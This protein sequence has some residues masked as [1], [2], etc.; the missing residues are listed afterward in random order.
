MLYNIETKNVKT[1]MDCMECPH[2]DKKTKECNGLGVACFEY[3]Q[4][5]QTCLDPVTKLPFNPN[6]QK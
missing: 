1:D 2:F 5:T 6:E 4:L 3:D